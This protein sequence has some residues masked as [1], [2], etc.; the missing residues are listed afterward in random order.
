MITP[1]LSGLD[2]VLNRPRIFRCVSDVV[3]IIVPFFAVIACGYFA[4]TSGVLTPAGA[5]GVNKLVA[6]FALPALVFGLMARSDIGSRFEI[7]L[8]IG[9]LAVALLLFAACFAFGRSVFAFDRAD[10]AVWSMAGVYGNTG[11][12]GIPLITVILGPEYA[13][14]VVLMMFIDLSIMVPL[15]ATLIESSRFQTSARTIHVL[16]GAFWNALKNPVV[17]AIVAGVA[18]SLA[19][20]AMPRMLDGFL[21]LAG[22]A[23][24]PCALFALG[25]SLGGQ[26]LSGVVAPGLTISAVKLVLHPLLLWL[27]FTYWL[28]LGEDWLLPVII[29][30]AMPIAATVYVVASQYQV[31]VL[32]TSTA[33]VI[34]TGISIVSVAVVF[35]LLPGL[36]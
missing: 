35:L 15:A 18:W 3:S 1:S 16:P 20:P 29:A 27:V 21:D 32:R 14:P 36:G 9:F 24:A 5:D 19:G 8:V 7:N 17:I 34:S 11:Y 33:I 10:A 25:A 6:G 23:A 26:K 2:S 30:A 28:P 31:M 13:V 22:A 4:A 12:M